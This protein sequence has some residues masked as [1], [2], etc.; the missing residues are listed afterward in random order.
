VP[1]SDGCASRVVLGCTSSHLEGSHNDDIPDARRLTVR[2]LQ[3]PRPRPAQDQPPEQRSRHDALFSVDE[4]VE[5]EAT[6]GVY[7]VMIV[8]YRESDRIEGRHLM[9]RLIAS[10][11]HSVPT[12]LSEVTSAGP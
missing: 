5:V 12:A 7:Q 3:H 10:I 2:P 11:S 4:H 6:W 1:R 9:T 8:A